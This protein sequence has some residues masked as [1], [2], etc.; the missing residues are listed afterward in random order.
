[1]TPPDQD[2]R[3]RGYG[4]VHPD[5]CIELV[6]AAA[7]RTVTTHDDTGERY[8]V[9][10]S[11][12]EIPLV[13]YGFPA[14]VAALTELELSGPAYLMGSWIVVAGNQ[15]EVEL[16]YQTR[17]VALPQHLTDIVTPSMSMRHAG[18]C[19]INVTN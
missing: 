1:M 12:Y 7:S 17:Y 10:P 5:G 16:H 11:G 19:A 2:G 9:A 8:A 3:Y 18:N 14:I 13:R 4:Q 6:D 15:V